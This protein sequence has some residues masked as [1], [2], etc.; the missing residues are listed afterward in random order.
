MIVKTLYGP[1]DAIIV[2]VHPDSSQAMVCLDNKDPS[3]GPTG[4]HIV[5][6]S[7]L[8]K[9]IAD[10][11]DGED[12]IFKPGEEVLATFEEGTF[13][14]TVVSADEYS[15]TIIILLKNKDPLKGPVGKAC[16]LFKWLEKIKN[17]EN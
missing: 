15:H 16:I 7:F 1:Q 4:I 13:E 17:E 8:E 3:A 10:K 6:F 12:Y 9:Q 11:Y 5:D 2:C 14:A